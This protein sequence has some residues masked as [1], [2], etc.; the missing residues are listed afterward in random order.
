[1]PEEDF[2]DVI[3]QI[4]GLH[5]ELKKSIEVIPDN[6]AWHEDLVKHLLEV[7]DHY[8]KVL[9]EKEKQWN[10][11][12]KYYEDSWGKDWYVHKENEKKKDI[13]RELKDFTNLLNY[14]KIYLSR[15]YKITDYMFNHPRLNLEKQK[16]IKRVLDRSAFE[17]TK[18]LA[19]NI[20]IVSL[21]TSNKAIDIKNQLLKDG[22]NIYYN[23][24]FTDFFVENFDS[25]KDD[26]YYGTMGHNYAYV[27]QYG[28]NICLKYSDKINYDLKKLVALIKLIKTM[29]SFNRAEGIDEDVGFL[30]KRD[31]F[32]KEIFSKFTRII[33]E[34][35]I[36]K[37]VLRN[38]ITSDSYSDEF[39]NNFFYY[40]FKLIK[41]QNLKRVFS[42][43]L[44]LDPKF[45]LIKNHGLVKTM[46]FLRR[47]QD[48]RFLP[49]FV[50][51]EIVIDYIKT[52]NSEDLRDYLIKKASMFNTVENL[53]EHDFL[54]VH[55][56]NAFGG[57]AALNEYEERRDDSFKNIVNNLE[58]QATNKFQL[59]A[60]T[61]KKGRVKLALTKRYGI[62]GSIGV[63][64]DS[65]YVYESYLKDANSESKEGGS[66]NSFKSGNAE[67]RVVV[68][69]SV[70][71]NYTY[72]E[73]LLRK[74]TIGALF[75]TRGVQQEHIDHLI[76]ISNEY[77]GKEYINP[78]YI[79]R[80]FKFGVPKMIK[81][82]YPVYEIDV[83]NNSWKIVYNP[84]EYL[85]EL[86]KAA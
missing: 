45:N 48:R 43:F 53:T 73:L 35:L 86:E 44:L 69:L 54:A 76:Q 70:T 40:S 1:M 15:L 38:F 39:K 24:K 77:S 20:G 74:W 42:L 31:K 67:K 62:N 28:F 50:D 9:D 65:G 14:S 7:E 13:E 82:Y 36:D 22:A 27:R 71:N 61:I 33:N 17:F 85:N 6:W 60:S 18:R 51:D 10:K 41:K 58:N 34:D 75:Y 72:N 25:F 16:Q 46:K 84:K 11:Q 5:K 64:F 59:C 78:N 32:V 56:T 79:N 2:M 52:L 8:Q 12:R 19:H 83:E 23:S 66:G 80:I 3:V 37:Y 81:K 63:I 4:K 21:R 68:S 55:V 57:G 30:L 49:L 47:V 29:T 26:F